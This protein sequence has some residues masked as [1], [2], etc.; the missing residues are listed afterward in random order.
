MKKMDGYFNINPSIEIEEKIEPCIKKYE[1]VKVFN[2]RKYKLN[3]IKYKYS[4]FG[5]T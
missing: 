2:Y 5:L 4:K 1:L 3:I